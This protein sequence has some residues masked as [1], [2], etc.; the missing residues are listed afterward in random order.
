MAKSVGRVHHASRADIHTF[1]GTSLVYTKHFINKMGKFNAVL[2]LIKRIYFQNGVPR[3]AVLLIYTM[4]ETVGRDTLDIY[5]N[6]G[7]KMQ[8]NMHIYTS[9]FFYIL[10][11]YILIPR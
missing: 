11:S 7:L 3:K 4:V 2:V 1:D 10:I 9:G 5:D 8:I 6:F